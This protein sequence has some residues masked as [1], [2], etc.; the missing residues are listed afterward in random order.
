M[1]SHGARHRVQAAACRA[2]GRAASRRAPRRC[3]W[4]SSSASASAW[5]RAFSAASICC[6]AAL[7]SAPR[8]F[9][10]S[11]DS[12]AERLEQLGHAAGLAEVARLG[13]LELGG[14]VRPA[15]SRLALLAPGLEVV[16]SVRDAVVQSVETTTKRPHTRSAFGRLPATSP[17]TGLAAPRS[18]PALHGTQASWAFTFST[19]LPKAAGSLTAMS[20]RTLR[21]MSIVGLLQAGHE[22]A[23]GDA[24]AAA[25]RIDAGDPEADGTRASWCG[26]HGRHTARRA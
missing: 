7:I 20:A 10:S 9:F 3:S 15:R 1:R 12:V 11:G 26:G 17:S 24:E 22:L 16:R 6:L 25:G 8:V 13:V 5:R 2:R 23:V 14:R 4:R 19:M 18:R 21:S